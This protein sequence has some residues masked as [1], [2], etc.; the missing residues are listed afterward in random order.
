MKKIA[1]PCLLLAGSILFLVVGCGKKEG[2]VTVIKLA[3]GLN[4]DHPVH[5]AMEFMAQRVAEKSQGKMRVDIYPGEQ[6]GNEKECLE[7]LQLGS[8]GMTKT[9]SSPLEAFVDEMKVLGLPYLFR[10]A[11]HYWKVLKGDIGKELLAAG[12]SKGLKGLC[13]YDA[14]ARSFYTVNKPIKAPADLAGLK[15]RVQQ[16]PIAIDMVKSMGASATPI[17]WGE[18]YTSLQQ[19]VVDGA[20]NNPPSLYTSKHYE[21][22]KYYTLDEHTMPPDV[23]L[24]SPIRWNKLTE[25]EKQILQEAVDESVDEERR[26]WAEFEKKSMEEVQKAGVEVI[27]PDKAPFREAV[28][29]MLEAQPDN[30]KALIQRI[31]E[32][33]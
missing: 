3:H 30:I 10:D 21:I 13:F 31:S 28:K 6:L 14:G 33:Q 19:G 4:T 17:P 24:I 20:E 25:Q 18:L 15:I 27:L 16:S 5:K 29:P 7:N 23:L 1:I 26:L 22:C 11:D 9:S 8:L 12:Q 32:V 2:D